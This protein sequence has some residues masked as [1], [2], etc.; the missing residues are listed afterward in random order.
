MTSKWLAGILAAFAF[1]VQGV[2]AQTVEEIY[3]GKTVT[4]V[5]GYGP[6]GGYDTFGRIISRHIGRH[7]PGNPNV[8][9]QN[10]P[11]A[12]SLTAAN[13]IYNN[14]PKDGLTF[15]LFARNMPVIGL[16]GGNKNFRFDPLNFT[17]L[18]STSDFSGDAYVL[19]VPKNDPVRTIQDA[20]RA[21]GPTLILGGT[22]AGGGSSDVPKILRDTLGLKMNLI[23][24]YPDSAAIY[25]AMEKGEVAGRTVEFSSVK[26]SRP[27]WLSANGPY[28]VLLQY[29]RATRH[30]DLLDVPTARE[31]AP[32][33][34]ARGIIEF[35]EASFTIA[36]PYAA[37][38]GVPAKQAEALQKAFKAV[39]S[40]PKFLEEAEKMG[41]EVSFVGP[42]TIIAT[43][44]KLSQA[45]P[46]VL[47]RVR[48]L[49][50][51]GK[52]GG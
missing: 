34:E 48:I 5:I 33:D 18:G 13:Y 2:Q 9:V 15:G 19:M 42:E 1:M 45:S 22:A 51:V 28:K 8:I 30:K 16:L 24:G 49:L 41:S 25:L 38:P 26:S 32:N 12:G 44:K 39:H 29:A 37:P 21:D 35:T 46:A 14:A 10:M 4:I 7:I 47:D 17:W 20:I 6:G 52:T 3:K 50:D 31:I 11:G 43:I 40:D 36:W 23:A 27:T